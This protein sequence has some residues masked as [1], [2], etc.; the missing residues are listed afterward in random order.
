VQ[1][2]FQAFQ[3]RREVR[4]DH[5]HIIKVKQQRLPVEAMQ[6]SFH[7]ALKRSWSGSQAKGEHFP[8][9]ES[10]P[11]DESRF[12]LGVL[13]ERDLPVTTDQVESGEIAT[14]SQR[15]KTFVNPGKWISVLLSYRV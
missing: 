13:T 3:M 1:D 4:S 11:R 15:I 7:Q 5:N 10:G 8:L 9:P 6:D 2:L 14:P 12:L